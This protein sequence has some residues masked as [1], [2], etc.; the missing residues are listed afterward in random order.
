MPKGLPAIL[1][2]GGDKIVCIRHKAMWDNIVRP[3]ATSQL[4]VHQSLMSLRD[5]L[6]TIFT[7]S[8]D[9]PCFRS[10]FDVVND[11]ASNCV[12]ESSYRRSSIA[13]PT[14]KTL[15]GRSGPLTLTVPLEVNLQR[16]GVRLLTKPRIMTNLRRTLT[17]PCPVARQKASRT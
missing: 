15:S 2:T 12:L 4:Q 3:W 16:A 11:T 8:S 10:D 1:K 7:I 14:S 9:F 6:S 13:S 5:E 17:P